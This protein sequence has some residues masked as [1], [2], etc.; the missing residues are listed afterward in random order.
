VTEPE[1]ER[2]LAER[3]AEVAAAM[4][5]TQR[6]QE[7]LRHRQDALLDELKRLDRALDGERPPE[8]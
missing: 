1:E 3:Q 7:A 5:E 4:E 6:R 2:D 8:D